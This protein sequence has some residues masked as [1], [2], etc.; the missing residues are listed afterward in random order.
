MAI[1][2]MHHEFMTLALEQASF[3]QLIARPNPAVGC[4]LV[5]SNQVVGTGYTQQVGGPHA[6]VMAIQAA[7]DLANGAIAYVTLEPCGHYGR[8]PPCSLALIE[9]GVS[10][11]VYGCQDPNPLVAGQGLSQLRTAN[12]EVIGPVLE[13]E[14]RRSNRGFLQRMKTNKPNVINKL[15]MSLDGRTAMKSGESQWIT[16]PEARAQVHLLRAQSC[17]VITGIGSILRDNP[18]MNVRADELALAGVPQATIELIKQPLR[19]VL[20]SQLRLPTSAKILQQPGSVLVITCVADLQRHQALIDMG[21]ELVVCAADDQ[22]KVDLSAVLTLL[23]QRQCNQVLV[24]AGAGLSGA[25]LKAGLTHH[26]VVY[27]A[28]KLMGSE[29]KAL[30]NLPLETMAQAVDVD[31]KG[32]SQVGNDWRIDATP[33]RPDN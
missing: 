27:L 26:L 12:I 16:G 9:A 15:A 5:K 22:G 17:A 7:G 8:T 1:Q 28:P 31:I 18:S 13:A 20:D 2:S 29:A 4:V 24:E 30:F 14:C 25:F 11:L 32:I 33:K 10:T 3:G 19:V 6:E 23:G 21:A